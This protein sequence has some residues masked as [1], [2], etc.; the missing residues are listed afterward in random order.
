VPPTTTEP[1]VDD[2]GSD[3]LDDGAEDAARGTDG[4]PGPSSTTGGGAV[5]GVSVGGSDGATVRTAPPSAVSG[6][7]RSVASSSAT[8]AS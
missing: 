7:T 1:D 6:S 2:D 4:S 3:E 5:D 8:A